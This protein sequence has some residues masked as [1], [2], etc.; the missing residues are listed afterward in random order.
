[1][2][3]P[4]QKKLHRGH[5]EKILPKTKYWPVV[6][7]ARDR[8]KFIQEVAQSSF[9]ALVV[10]TKN[11]SLKEDLEMTVYKERI[12]VKRSPWRVDPKNELDYW[13]GIR[14]ELGKI[15]EPDSAEGRKKLE[16]IL[17][18]IVENYSTEISGNF[19]RSFY[20]FM[21]GLITILFA[22]LLN[23]TRIKGPFSFFSSKL[24]I[25]DQIRITGEIDQIRSLAQKG[26]IVM[27]PTHSSNLDSVLIGWVIQILGLPPFIYGAGLNLFNMRIFA[28][29]MNSLGAFKVDRR[30]KNLIYLET[31]KTYSKLAIMRGCHSLFF[32]GGGRSR[33]GH[34]EKSLKLGLLS[35]AIEAQRDNYIGLKDGETAQ[36][37]F[38]VPVVL[39]YHFV[40]EAPVLIKD[41]LKAQGQERY[42]VENDEFSTSYK[43]F[44][45]L[46]KFFTRGSSISVSIG[47]AMDVLGNPVDM[48]GHSFDKNN[49]RIH[50]KDYFVTNG[51][52][53]RDDQRDHQYVRLLSGKIVEHYTIYCEVFTS[54]L[55]AFVAFQMIKAQNPNQDLYGLLRLPEEYLVIPFEEFKFQ[56][57]KL[58]DVLFKLNEENKLCL[59]HHMDKDIDYVIN[60][61][62][63]NVGLYHTKRP[64]KRNKRG[65]IEVN[66]MDNLYY[67][68]NRL[69]IYDLD[70]YFK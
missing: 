12:R 7:L 37:V 15:Q 5:Y 22:R 1:M 19:R 14:A 46:L 13:D 30:K 64:L 56:I 34:L 68:H 11:R 18:R 8:K 26:T 58:R 47:K 62:L 45:F 16:N 50:T 27:V 41:Y 60:H 54:H 25:E 55:V 28:Y 51:E 32:P 66:N 3:I 44:S 2:K 24:D 67:Y 52:I 48:D 20:R 53:S 70:S 40:L 43:T 63:A 61:G 29:F 17:R 39:N 4:G 6:Q 38:I 36:K 49:N 57:S 65:D 35:T 10:E 69:D 33:S 59:G 9:E 42:Y 21:R 23:A 31:L